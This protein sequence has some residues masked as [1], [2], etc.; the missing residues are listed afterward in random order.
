[1][2]VSIVCFRERNESFKTSLVNGVQDLCFQCYS[3][4]QI[5]KKIFRLGLCD[6][7]STRTSRAFTTID[8]GR[9]HYMIPPKFNF[10][11]IGHVANHYI[12]TK[13]TTFYFDPTYYQILV[14][15]Q[16]ILPLRP[17]FHH[18]SNR[19]HCGLQFNP[20]IVG[21]YWDPTELCHSI[22]FLHVL[23]CVYISDVPIYQDYLSTIVLHLSLQRTAYEKTICFAHV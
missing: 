14:G 7:C 17:C 2:C 10:S 5:D 12:W 8:H 11:G 21:F 15:S 18:T 22:Q 4:E 16:W 19:H 23:A 13:V 1:M 20:T 3:F 6:N 9:N